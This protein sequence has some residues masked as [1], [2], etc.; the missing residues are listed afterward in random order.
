MIHR[1]LLLLCLIVSNT[2]SAEPCTVKTKNK[3]I[4]D[5]IRL[6]LRTEEC[7]DSDR[8]VVKVLLQRGA[9]PKQLLLK[10]TR[11][12]SDSPTGGANFINLDSDHTPE[13]ELTGYCSQPNCE[14]DIYKLAENHD[15]IYHF[16][17]GSYSLISKTENYLITGA[18][19]NYS[20]WE[21]LAYELSPSQT[22]PIGKIFQ[23]SI[24]ISA[25]ESSPA[26]E[27]LK[28]RCTIS[29]MDARKNLTIVESPP[30]ELLKFCEHYGKNYVLAQTSSARRKLRKAP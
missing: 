15:S 13:I 2:V 17:S 23:Y 7:P 18:Y 6:I 11:A 30:V 19:G 24:H 14:Y 5:E 27:V 4:E 26:G 12:L 28:S 29:S 22:Y 9:D 16:Y 25:I 20:S 1:A 10:K 8:R 21:Y 3:K